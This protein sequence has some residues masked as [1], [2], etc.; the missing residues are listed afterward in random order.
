MTQYP[1]PRISAMRITKLDENL[2][3]ILPI[4]ANVMHKERAKIQIIALN[5]VSPLL[6]LLEIETAGKTITLKEAKELLL[7]FLN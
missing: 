1:Q 3:Q 7:Q 5:A 2:K 6:S 4:A